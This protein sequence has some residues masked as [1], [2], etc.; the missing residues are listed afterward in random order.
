MRFKYSVAALSICFHFHA[1]F[2]K[3]VPNNRLAPLLSWCSLLG[4][5]GS[6]TDIGNMFKM[7]DP[8]KQITTY[9]NKQRLINQKYSALQCVIGLANL[10]KGK[11]NEMDHQLLFL[12]DLTVGEMN[13]WPFWYVELFKISTQIKNGRRYPTY[14]ESDRESYSQAL[15]VVPGIWRV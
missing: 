5:P 11:F 4:N 10:Q 9:W 8:W 14:P 1:I 2:G 15:E 7:M 6:T 3:I 13:T 12:F